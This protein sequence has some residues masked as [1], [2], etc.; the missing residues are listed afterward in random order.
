MPDRDLKLSG[1]IPPMATPLDSAGGLDIDGVERLVA[2]LI[3]GGV[4]G[5]FVLGTTGEGVSLAYRLRLQ[6]IEQVCELVEGRIPVL[7]GVTDTSLAESLELAGA[8]YGAGADAVVLAPPYYL[9]LDSVQ[10]ETHARR[11]AEASPLPVVLYNIPSCTHNAFDLLTIQRCRELENVIGV[12]D[13]SG[14]MEFFGELLSTFR[15]EP[16]F[17]GMIGPE[18][19]I[20]SAVLAGADGGVCGGANLLPHLFVGIYE[21]AARGDRATAEQLQAVANRL[22]QAV[23]RVGPSWPTSIMQGVKAG[24]E[25][26]GIA[27]RH[28][29]SPIDP[30]DD[31]QVEQI[32]IALEELAGDAVRQNV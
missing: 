30:L 3:G 16:G 32:R 27:T 11:F 14:D 24:L 7:V 17:S 29:A 4:H 21:A 25:T 1:V 2:K 26:L 13:S 9:P 15:D 31:G 22:E 18:N 6:L 23:Y 10:V 20:A 5:L 28:T 12:K 8:A 19:Q